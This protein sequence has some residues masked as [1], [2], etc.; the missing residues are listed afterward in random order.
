MDEV[1]ARQWVAD[2]FDVSR[3]TRCADFVEMVREE[4]SHQNLVSGASLG[5]VWYRHIV[6]SA[7]LIPLARHAPGLWID[8]GTG[9]GFPGMVIAILT[10]RPVHLIEPRKRRADFLRRSVERL[11][12]NGRVVTIADRAE[13]HE[14]KAAVISARAVAPLPELL[15]AAAHLSTAKT[16]WLLPKGVKARE[17]VEAARG[18]W[19]GVFHV[20][21]S[22]T[23]QRS[24][25]V[26]AKGVA[27][28]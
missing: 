17:E 1:A 19:H 15:A 8:V 16:L 7:Q 5:E 13:R 27:R 10:D 3:E 6:D 28:R 25:I 11:G 12:L 23:E 26:T 14:E 20:E 18:T 24:L 2:H 21:Q 9:A 4:A 22:L